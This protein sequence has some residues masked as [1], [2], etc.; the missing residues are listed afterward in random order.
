MWPSRVLHWYRVS[1]RRPKRANSMRP[2]ACSAVCCGLLSSGSSTVAGGDGYSSSLRR[3]LLQCT[4]KRSCTWPRLP[5]LRRSTFF[6]SANQH[7]YSVPCCRRRTCQGRGRGPEG[8][9]RVVGGWQEVGRGGARAG[10]SGAPLSQTIG[11]ARSACAVC[12]CSACAVH[13]Q[14]LCSAHAS[15]PARSGQAARHHRS[16]RSRHR[17]GRRAARRVAR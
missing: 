6:C 16:Q 3:G 2:L 14:C 10:R 17:R 4:E 15:P 1:G 11:C 13:V 5:L 9:A 8:G 12:M 7:V